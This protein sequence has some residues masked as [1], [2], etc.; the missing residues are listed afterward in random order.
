MPSAWPC[1]SAVNQINGSNMW[2][3]NEACLHL[4]QFLLFDFR[5][6]FI[7]IFYLPSETLFFSSLELA[8]WSFA[9]KGRPGMFLQ[10][11]LNFPLSSDQVVKNI[12][13]TLKPEVLVSNGT[14]AR[15]INHPAKLAYL[16]GTQLTIADT[17]FMFLPAQRFYDCFDTLHYFE[18]KGEEKELWA[19][20]GNW[21]LHR[22]N[23][24]YSNKAKLLKKM[25]KNFKIKF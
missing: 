19:L 20:L 11:Q 7:A 23:L 22:S 9:I 14:R 17:W 16:K 21:V 3:V 6:R 25:I 8:T 24:I 15:T 12:F 13:S 18:T 4:L 5:S 10:L 2:S 1:L